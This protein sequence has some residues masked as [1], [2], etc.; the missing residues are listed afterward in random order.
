MSQQQKV[1]RHLKTGRGITPLIAMQHY[2]VM[3]LA[4]VV[5]R[6][7]HSGYQIKTIMKKDARGVEYAEYRLVGGAF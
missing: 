7:R 3:R 1:L 4:A 6:L 5:Y 2:G